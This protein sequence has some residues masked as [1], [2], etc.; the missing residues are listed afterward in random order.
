MNTL[1]HLVTRYIAD[2]LGRGEI[3]PVSAKTLDQHLRSFARSFGER[4][5]DQLGLAATERWIAA[6]DHAGLAKATQASRLSSLR[7][8]AQWCVIR[9]HVQKDWTLGVRK[10]RRPRQRPRDMRI[11]H[12]RAILTAAATSRERLIV[13]LMFGA[14]L[15]CIEVARLHVDDFD[16]LDNTLFVIGKGKHERIV[17]ITNGVRAAIET[18]LAEAGHGVGPMI[19]QETA[20]SRPLSASRISDIVQGLTK[21]SGVKVRPFDGRSAHGLRALAASDLYDA[22][23]DLRV[24]GDLLGH[25]NVATT[26]I[27]LRSATVE[28]IRAAQQAR[29]AA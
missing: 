13:W 2:R 21:A 7:N 28:K 29:E 17:P 20:T 19:R 8:F 12:F 6:M 14:G 22:C 18:Y 10:I 26:S 4:P 11:E 5:L 1:N 24:V 9:G 16:Q 27:Y 25:V 3:E 15:R 23:H